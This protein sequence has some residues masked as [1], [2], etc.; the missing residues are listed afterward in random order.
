MTI[1]RRTIVSGNKLD[2]NQPR[3]WPRDQFSTVDCPVP[4]NYYRAC[5]LLAGSIAVDPSTVNPTINNGNVKR[6][7][8]GP[9]ET[10][11]FHPGSLQKLEAIQDQDILNLLQPYLHPDQQNDDNPCPYVQEGQPATIDYSQ[12]GGS[13]DPTAHYR[14]RGG[15]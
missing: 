4:L 9:L 2:Q 5:V 12:Y 6:D 15:Y 10:E 13:I 14:A 7:K 1:L 8:T 11:F 3:F